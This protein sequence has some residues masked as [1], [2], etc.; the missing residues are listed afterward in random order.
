VVASRLISPG[1]EIREADI[2]LKPVGSVP[3]GAL[4]NGGEVV[5]KRS[6]VAIDAGSPVLRKH[7]PA[8]NPLASVLRENER[9]VAVKVDD[10]IGVGGFL[11]PDDRVDVL[12]YLRGDN[13]TNKESKALVAVRSVR[14]LSYGDDVASRAA[15]G[16][17]SKNEKSR[18]KGAGTAVLAASPEDAVR[19][20]LAENAGALRLALRSARGG[21]EE[22]GASV[23]LSEL[24]G[25]A[26]GGGGDADAREAKGPAVEIYWGTEKK[27]FYF[28]DSSQKQKA[29]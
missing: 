19:L 10:L 25:I 28:H 5:G 26:A 29:H 15:D 24:S 21:E 27:E 17:E 18:S 2:D 11:R 3:E 23:S 8:G 7:F 20:A 4:T 13:Q 12:V 14:V 9:A 1:E 22:D 16:K 6:L